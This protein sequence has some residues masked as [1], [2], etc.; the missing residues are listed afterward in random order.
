MSGAALNDT[1]A[2]VP[3]RMAT[4]RDTNGDALCAACVDA[5][6]A[7]RR[8]EFFGHQGERLPPRPASGSPAQPVDVTAIR[9]SAVR[10][11]RASTSTNTPVKVVPGRAKKAARP[12]LA[13]L[14]RVSA[15]ADEHELEVR[16]QRVASEIGLAHARRLLE[17]LRRLGRERRPDRA[18]APAHRA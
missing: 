15:S 16:F 2:R 5:R 9:W 6:L 8:A 17:E 10:V 1:A 7:R 11:T 3:R 18:N 4:K 14:S 13:D 12:A